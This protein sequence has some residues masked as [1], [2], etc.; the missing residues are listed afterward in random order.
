MFTAGSSPR[1]WGQASNDSLIS[2]SIG[3]IPTRVGT[4]GFLS[5]AFCVVRIIP[6]RVGTRDLRQAYRDA[7]QDHPHACGDKRHLRPGLIK[8]SGS[9]PRVW[10]QGGL[11]GTG[12]RGSRIIPTRVGTSDKRR[13]HIYDRADH[14]HACGDKTELP[15]I[16]TT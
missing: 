9:S 16:S 3:I 6:T 5:L 15:F 11:R 1:V 14:P 2:M 13:K 8:T 12:A 10:G 4:R 7:C